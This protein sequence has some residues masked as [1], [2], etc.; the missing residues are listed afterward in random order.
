MKRRDFILRASPAL[1]LALAGC[2]G[3]SDAT[4][5]TATSGALAQTA[6]SFPLSVPWVPSGPGLPT[7]TLHASTSGTMPYLAT[8]FPLEGAVP[9]GQVVESAEDPA[10]RSTVLSR[11]PDGS[12]Q[13]VVLAG[14]TVVTAGAPKTISLRSTNARGAALTSARVA[15]LISSIAVDFGTGVQRLED[16]SK[17]ERVWWAN[18]STICCRYRLPCGVG[19]MEAVIDIHAFRSDRALV[20]VVVENSRMNSAAPALPATQTYSNATVT[21]NGSV[22]ATVSSPVAGQTFSGRNGTGQYA[23]GHEPFRAW[24]CSTWVGGDPGIVVTHDAASMQSHPLF[25]LAA[26]A[27]GI[28]LRTE[29]TRSYDTYAP[30]NPCR[31]RV[32]NM[33]GGGEYDEIAL[34]TRS[35]SHYFQ[36]GNVHAARAVVNHA[37]G[38]LCCDINYR[39]ASSGLVP[40][41][42]D[43][44]GKSGSARTWPVSTNGFS[45]YRAREP[46]FENAHQPAHGLVAFLCR[47]SPA[48]I[49]IAQKIFAWNCVDSDG[50]SGNGRHAFDQVRARGWRMRSYGHALFL[51]PD[52]LTTWKAS[53]RSMLVSNKADFDSFLNLPWNTL[54]V[55]WGTSP[56]DWNSY[57]DYNRPRWQTPMWQTAFVVMSVTAVANAKVLRGTDATTWSAMADRLALPLVRQINEAQA[58]EWR[59]IPYAETIGDVV[60]GPPKR[61]DMG[62][63][64]WGA[65]RRSDYTGTVPAPAG[66]WLNYSDKDFAWEAGSPDSS[67]GYSYPSQFWGAF[68]AAVER[69]VPG[70]AAA[71]DK[72]TRGITN[73]AT[74]RQGFRTDPR[75]NRWPRNK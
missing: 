63:G 58:G 14:E 1:A 4:T 53:G 62:S 39:D 19:V 65:M 24:Y 6:S 44:A 59:A 56:S 13:V 34:F 57:A 18:E 29:Y 48:F 68:C 23:G 38:A 75:F 50:G 70:A 71:W 17:P 45:G 5:A 10:L 47:P 54:G 72:V 40:S 42:A 51:T 20:E 15:Q 7:L 2:G 3:A 52:D 69:D 16:F 41:A 36:T 31:V 26:E 64:N 35:Q 30:W 46:A 66:P 55:L 9:S 21:V 43:L 25:F 67:A 49:E 28:D 8:A 11:W 60:E 73:L 74:W 33:G 12:A 32:P 37:L 22:A 61:I 27:C